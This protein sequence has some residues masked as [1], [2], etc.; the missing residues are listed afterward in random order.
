MY[1]E[2]EKKSLK[3][4]GKKCVTIFMI[5]SIVAYSDF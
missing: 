2:R 5:K 4:E 1:N 3:V